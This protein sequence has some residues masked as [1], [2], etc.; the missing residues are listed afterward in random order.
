VDAAPAARGIHATETI[1]R[2]NI[3]NRVE[4]SISKLFRNRFAV[5]ASHRMSCFETNK[6]MPESTPDMQRAFKVMIGV[7]G[8]NGNDVRS[9]ESRP[10]G[11]PWLLA[12]AAGFV[13]PGARSPRL[14]RFAEF[15]PSRSG[16]PAAVRRRSRRRIASISHWSH[17][18]QAILSTSSFRGLSGA[19]SEVR[20]YWGRSP[21]LI[22][23][24]DWPRDRERSRRRFARRAQARPLGE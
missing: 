10:D 6:W 1:E 4:Y 13:R 2:R 5:F 18:C 20:P 24:T 11:Y 8:G 21:R 3:E 12:C 17:S 9:S 16:S 7:R 22:D 23:T 14:R 19:I 15:H